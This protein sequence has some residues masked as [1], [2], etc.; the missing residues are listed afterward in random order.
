MNLELIRSDRTDELEQFLANIVIKLKSFSQDLHKL[1][2]TDF[3]PRYNKARI[4]IKNNTE[5]TIEYLLL[6][7]FRTGSSIGNDNF[8]T[9]PIRTYNLKPK[10]KAEYEL[11]IFDPFNVAFTEME[12]S[13]ATEKDWKERQKVENWLSKAGEFSYRVKKSWIRSLIK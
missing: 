13:V 11:M 8:D 3:L 7:V 12:I 6:R 1:N 5:T 2:P 10:E 4:E 9:L